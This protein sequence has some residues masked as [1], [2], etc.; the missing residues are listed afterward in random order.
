MEGKLF[1]ACEKGDISEFLYLYE[2]D[3]SILWQRTTGS[4]DT[5]LHLACR[6]N[7]NKLASTIINLQPDTAMATNDIGYTP[8]HEACRVGDK[9]IVMQLLEACPSVAYIVNMAKESALS[10]ACSF[11]HSEVASELCRRMNFGGWDNIGASCL[12][13]AA[14]TGH[15]DIVRKINGDTV[16]HLAAKM[17][18]LEI[19]ELLL[20]KHGMKVNATNSEGRTAFDELEQI[21]AHEDPNVSSDYYRKRVIIKQLTARKTASPKSVNDI[22]QAL[23]VVAGIIMAITYLAGLNPPGGLWQSLDL[24]N[25]RN[26]RPGKAI[27][28]ETAPWLVTV[29]LVSDTLGFI[30]SLSLIPII[31]ILQKETVVYV[32][33]LVVVALISIEVAFILGLIMILDTAIFFRV[34]IVLLALVT[35]AGMWW[36]WEKLKLRLLNIKSNRNIPELQGE[37]LDAT[38]PEIHTEEE[39]PH[40]VAERTSEDVI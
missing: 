6:S 5:P 39:S 21:P 37:Y 38:A 11:G 24:G 16:L 34:V 28:S 36:R 18:A 20:S 26:H 8:L 13:I 14:S 10:I 3:K 22:Q 35:S 15:A 27:Q 25:G 30:V 1:R 31:M 19:M 4:G 17:T 32:N 29:F 2:A 12:L 23:I 7:H 9:E 33:S 40:H